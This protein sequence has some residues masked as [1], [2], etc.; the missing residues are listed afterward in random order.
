MARMHLLEPGHGIYSWLSESYSYIEDTRDQ[1][2]RWIKHG[3]RDGY[4][5]AQLRALSDRE[6]KVHIE[7]RMSIAAVFNALLWDGF[8]NAAPFSLSA[9][10]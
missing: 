6:L 2:P 1:D 7:A 9:L 5:D 3:R 10:G 8:F 4:S